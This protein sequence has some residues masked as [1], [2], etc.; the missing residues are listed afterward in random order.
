MIA[1][2][3]A[4]AATQPFSVGRDFSPPIPPSNG[5]YGYVRPAAAPFELRYEARAKDLQLEMAA[6]KQSDGGRLTWEHK[7]YLHTKLVALLD[8]Y[9]RDLDREN[10]R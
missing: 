1:A 3:L 9:E 5:G 8:A 2:L 7:A 4:L 6:L 10:G